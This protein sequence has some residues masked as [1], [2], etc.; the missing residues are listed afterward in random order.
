M[1]VVEVTI[2]ILSQEIHPKIG[3]FGQNR[4]QQMKHT[5]HNVG[6]RKIFPRHKNWRKR[7]ISELNFRQRQTLN[8]QLNATIF[9]APLQTPQKMGPFCQN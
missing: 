7:R 8:P 4:F 9:I 3:P 1:E 6:K 5:F 2:I